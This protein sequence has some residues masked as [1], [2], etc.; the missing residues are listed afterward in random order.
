MRHNWNKS[1]FH[2]SIRNRDTCLF[3]LLRSFVFSFSQFFCLILYFIVLGYIQAFL[4][5]QVQIQRHPEKVLYV[6]LFLLFF[7]DFILQIHLS[8]SFVLPER[9]PNPTHYKQ[10]ITLIHGNCVRRHLMPQPLRFCF[11]MFR[12]LKKQ[13][14]NNKNCIASTLH[15]MEMEPTFHDDPRVRPFGEMVLFE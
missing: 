4:S 10:A 11:V 1:M 2:G 7:I 13:N 9:N 8:S 3:V 12:A 14:N 6:D 15:V 5:S